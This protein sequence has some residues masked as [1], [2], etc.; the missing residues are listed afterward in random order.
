MPILTIIAAIGKNRELGA[1]NDLLWNLPDEMAH[2]RNTTRGLSVVMGRKTFESIGKPLPNRCNIVLTRDEKLHIPG[3]IT[4]TSLE[5][6]LILS[7][8]F[9]EELFVIGGSKIYEMSLPFAERMYLT[10]VDAAFPKADTFFP[11]FDKSRW[12]EVDRT[13]HKTDEKHKYAFDII[14]FERA[15]DE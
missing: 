12:Q 6:A 10:I 1:N 2:F 14:T 8:N 15:D 5:E 9:G 7:K 13:H 3:T 11:N 4:C